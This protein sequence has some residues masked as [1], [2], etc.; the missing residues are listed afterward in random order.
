MSEPDPIKRTF[1]LV[2]A[3][4]WTRGTVIVSIVGICI[5]LCTWVGSPFFTTDQMIAAA[6]SGNGDVLGGFDIAKVRENMR[7][8]LTALAQPDERDVDDNPASGFELMAAPRLADAVLD[9]VLTPGHVSDLVRYG[10][11]RKPDGSV[12]VTYSA[13]YLSP[14]V[15]ALGIGG[16]DAQPAVLTFEEMA[17]SLGRSL[18]SRYPRLR[19]SPTREQ[20]Q[21]R[22]HPLSRIL[23]RLFRLTIPAPQRATRPDRLRH[24]PP[25]YRPRSPLQ[26]PRKPTHSHCPT[27]RF[28]TPPASNL[29]PNDRMSRGGI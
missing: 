4:S 15:F 22:R 23:P 26:R 7:P 3:A 20:L 13:R 14:N 2:G 6:K 12:S 25:P 24:R 28:Q 10:I 5:F 8:S 16:R 21:I 17:S 11:F 19:S 9:S 29:L 27:R 18:A 1:Y